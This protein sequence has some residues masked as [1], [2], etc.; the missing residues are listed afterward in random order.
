MPRNLLFGNTVNITLVGRRQY[1]MNRI[2]IRI[3]CIYRTTLVTKFFCQLGNI[4]M[5]LDYTM[6]T[7]DTAHETFFSLL[8]VGKFHLPLPILFSYYSQMNAYFCCCWLVHFLSGKYSSTFVP[9][10]FTA[11]IQRSSIRTNKSARGKCAS[12]NCE[13]KTTTA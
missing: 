13:V 5:N 9:S 1:W 4:W 2:R 10:I 12:Y 3:G 8:P 7:L 11:G 6:Q